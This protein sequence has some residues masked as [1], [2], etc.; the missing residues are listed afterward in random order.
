M[1]VSTPGGISATPRHWHKAE[2]RSDT[3]RL[4][5]SPL[6]GAEARRKGHCLQKGTK[7]AN[8]TTKDTFQQHIKG[9]S[10]SAP[11]AR[12]H[13]SQR[14]GLAPAPAKSNQVWHTRQHGRTLALGSPLLC[15]SPTDLLPTH[16]ALPCLKRSG[17]TTAPSLTLPVITPW[18]G[19][20]PPQSPSGWGERPHT[21]GLDLRSLMERLY[22]RVGKGSPRPCCN[23]ARACPACSHKWGS[24]FPNNLPPCT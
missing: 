13:P 8:P 3:K 5:Y 11:P 6:S 2:L 12:P 20:A 9:G 14:G 23:G 16:R 1:L 15:S 4:S 22:S 7:P 10:G 19:Q 24:L 18:V 21:A 17:Q